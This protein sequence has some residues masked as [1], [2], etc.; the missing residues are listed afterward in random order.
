MNKE[1]FLKDLA[2]FA[3]AATRAAYLLGAE[4]GVHAKETAASLYML[5]RHIG[6][7]SSCALPIFDAMALAMI[8]DAARLGRQEEFEQAAKKQADMN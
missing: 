5:L 2:N 1:Q 6:I 4:D 7:E 3:A 8:P